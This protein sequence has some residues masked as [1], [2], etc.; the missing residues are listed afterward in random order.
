[1]I[2]L[3]ILFAGM[4]LLLLWPL[5]RARGWEKP[6]TALAPLGLGVVLLFFYPVFFDGPAEKICES[7]LPAFPAGSA[8]HHGGSY[9]SW[10]LKLEGGEEIPLRGADGEQRRLTPAKIHIP[11]WH[12]D[13]EGTEAALSQ[14]LAYRCAPPLGYESSAP[15]RFHAFSA[16]PLRLI[17]VAGEP[18]E[19]KE[20]ARVLLAKQS[21]RMPVKV[22]FLREG[23]RNTI[24]LPFTD[25]PEGKENAVGYF[26][27]ELR[28]VPAYDDQFGN[29]VPKDEYSVLTVREEQPHT[30]TGRAL[31]FAQGPRVF[32]LNPFSALR[33]GAAS[34]YRML[35]LSGSGSLRF[36]AKFYKNTPDPWY[37]L[38]LRSLFQADYLYFRLATLLIALTVSLA[39]V[40]AAARVTKRAPS[41]TVRFAA[42]F[43]ITWLMMLND[44]WVVVTY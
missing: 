39:L 16:T 40:A 8:W 26:R 9:F 10:R 35:G 29:V 33:A 21:S 32:S 37:L 28:G 30:V 19:T 25:T 41:S 2:D 11:W 22:N 3:A 18:L 15:A 34:A 4:I 24:P 1:M 12:P 38:P 5:A 23:S 13:T 17:S 7:D 14:G 6:R 42:V 36:L 20:E 31:G 43:T 27:L 44:L